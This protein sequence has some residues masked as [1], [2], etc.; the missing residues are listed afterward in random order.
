MSEQTKAL[1]PKLRFPEFLQSGEWEEKKLGE[2]GQTVS[3][4]S[5]KSAEDFGTGKP[6]V[7]YKQV[8]DSA[9]IDFAKCGQVQISVNEKQ[10]RL[11]HGDILFTGSSETPEEV[12]FASVVL[13]A[14]SEPVYLNSFCFSFRPNNLGKLKPEFSRY[15]FHSPIYR[16]LIGVLAQGI[17]R[18]NISKTGFLNLNLPIPSDTNEQQKIADC[19][20][21]LDNLIAAENLRIAALKDYKKGLMQQL[22]PAQGETVPKLRFPEFESAGE[23][24]FIPMNMLAKRCKQKNQ[25]LKI[26]KVL[27]N[28]AEFGVLDQRD[29]FDK[30]IANQGNLEGYYI[31]EKGDYVYNPRISSMAPV[32]PISKNNVETGVMSPLYTVFRFD[33][34]HNDFYALFFKTTGWHDYMRQVASTGARHDRMAITNDDFMAMPIPVTSNEEQQKIADCLSS[35]DDLINEQVQKLEVYKSHKKGLMQQLFPNLSEAG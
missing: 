7:T 19:L 15:L 10:N 17:T 25:N 2:I 9:Q 5:G 26:K 13:D 12:G 31:V 29:Y 1:I 6:F 14:P 20:S 8:F 32:G 22:F 18:F 27:T 11:Q 30:D 23:W 35:L 34:P 16:K 4:L 28:S 24:K 33:N 3:G 21:P